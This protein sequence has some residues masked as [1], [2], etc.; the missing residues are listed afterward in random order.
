MRYYI[1]SCITFILSIN[2]VS[3]QLDL[4]FETDRGFYDSP[5]QLELTVNDPAAFIRYT[6]N[7][8]PPT[9]TT[10]TLYSG[11]ISIN[12]TSHIRAVA[13]TGTDTTKVLTHTYIFV[14]DVVNQPNTIAGYP[15]TDYAFDA[16]IK[17][18]PTYGSQLIDAL[19]QIPTISLVMDL[20]QLDSVHNVELPGRESIEAPTSVELLFPNNNEKNY[21]V[22]GGIE[23]AGGSSFSNAKR[24]L[25]LSFKS[26]YGAA[27]FEYP[28]FGKDA[29]NDFDQIALR[30]GF[31]GCMNLGIGNARGG[32]ND[33]ADQVVRNYQISMA[34]DGAGIHG[35]FMHLY[36][37]GVYWG[38]YNPSERGNASFGESYYGGK[39]DDYD[40][41]KRK[42]ALDGDTMAWHT[43]NDMVDNLNMA[44]PG[45]YAD[46]QEYVEVEQFADYAIIT[47][48]A[49][50]SDDNRNGKN[51]FVTRNR[52]Q[53]D[54]FRFW[55]WDTEPALG[56]YWTFGVANFGTRPY[57][58]I[59]LSLLDNNDF[60]TLVADRLECH[61]FND[62]AL[63]AQNAVDEYMRVYNSTK[64]AMLAEAARWVTDAEYDEF[65]NTKN[66]IVNQY[67][68]GRAATT[69]QLYRNNNVYPNIDAVQFSQYGGTVASGYQ[70]SL[71]NPNGAGTIY[72]TTDGTD[73]RASGGGISGSAQVYSGSISLADGATEIK[74]RVRVNGTWSAM[75]P[76]R[77]YADVDYTDLV[78]NEIMY[79]P[80]DTCSQFFDELDY[81]EI[82]NNGTKN[83][84]LTDTKL[85]C[86]IDYT[87][88]LGAQIA[89]G[90]YLILAENKDS[91]NLHYGFMPHGEYNGGLSNDGETLIYED[92]AG[93]IID[94]LTYNDKNPWDEAPD[95]KG[96]SLELR[97]PSLN[98]SDPL[99]WFRSD[100]LCG[101]PGQP[102]GRLCT[103][104]ATPIVINEI[105]YNPTTLPNTGD[106]V[107]L[108]NP[109]PGAVDISNWEFYDNENKYVIP[110]GTTLQP[111][112]YL[113]LAEDVALFSAAFPHLNLG[114]YIGDLGFNLSNGGERISLFDNNKCL[115]DFVIYND[116]IPWDTI[117]DGNGPS[118]SLITPNS[119]NTLPQSWE[120]SSNINSAFGTPG[121]ENAPCI[122]SNIILPN[123]I[124]AG[125]P[126]T[127]KVDSVYNNMDF[128][129]FVAGATPSSFTTNS[130][131]I[132]WNTPGTYNIQL[133]GRRFECTKIYTQSVTVES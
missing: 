95:G 88:D 67:L 114:Q 39:K 37:N 47:N 52:T 116:K 76:R 34:E 61:C 127:I 89:P 58:N 5:F 98:N 6:T 130:E 90:D 64:I 63:T 126:A 87:F 132:I 65:V 11:P 27:K 14:N 78:I 112:E 56:H 81:I 17:N 71:S 10:G 119:D 131:T 101:S 2:F 92:F 40:A 104:A 48:Y 91:F 80:D 120:S 115:S 43:L 86:G 54:G 124:C 22:N 106:W 133:I 24:N 44:N 123:V 121:R 16:S 20:V 12:T 31:H 79:H 38:V 129:W 7:G 59:F 82:Y 35:N 3:A 9:T 4:D 102:N 18:H 70:L 100:N 68:P 60:K 83:I 42:A 103:N 51:S 53:T 113:I 32:S 118:L 33:I 1:A 69:I 30:P 109:N 36:I 96:P 93:N 66:R 55:I 13:Y 128:T 45:N 25:R 57:N 111:D 26:I 117:P 74:A 73:P 77:F 99:N 84:H 108:Y 50:H 49:P 28:I 41:I 46:V 19:T 105:N 122:E 107:E 85:S 94:S 125:F 29:A 72:Y 15:S 97:D 23:R 110:S 62:G 21:Q 75:C 8:T